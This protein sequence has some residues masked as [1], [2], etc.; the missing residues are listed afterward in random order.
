M[1]FKLIAVA[2][3]TVIGWT[4]INN[5]QPN[6]TVSFKNDSK[7]WIRKFVNLFLVF[8]LIEHKW[9][10][11]NDHEFEKTTTTGTIS[12][13]TTINSAT[14]NELINY[15]TSQP[16]TSRSTS[17]EL[18]ISESWFMFRLQNFILVFFTS[19]KPMSILSDFQLKA[20]FTIINFI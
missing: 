19:V 5:V 12:Y 6:L 3:L 16:F 13:T 20:F 18:R 9:V 14:R 7:I 11:E 15:T 8:D 17:D 1:H 4:A 2:V 10:C